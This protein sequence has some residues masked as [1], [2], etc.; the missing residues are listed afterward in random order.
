MLTV[1]VQEVVLDVLAEEGLD[2]LA[3]L[4]LLLQDVLVILRVIPLGDSCEQSAA[5]RRAVSAAPLQR[6][7]CF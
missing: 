6:Y 3:D 4:L 1:F 7:N 5:P 2:R